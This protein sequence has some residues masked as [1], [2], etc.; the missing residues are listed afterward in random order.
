MRTNRVR[1]TRKRSLRE[2]ADFY[3]NEYFLSR[4]RQHIEELE[5]MYNGQTDLPADSVQI[6][7]RRA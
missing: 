6:E 7:R 1:M 5:H 2:T 4:D 3:M